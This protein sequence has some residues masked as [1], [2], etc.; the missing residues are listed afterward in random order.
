MNKPGR[1]EVGEVTERKRKL[2]G[3]KK[4]DKEGRKKG[5]GVIGGREERWEMERGNK[6]AGRRK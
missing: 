6:D 4:A 2:R 1:K 5:D 3:R